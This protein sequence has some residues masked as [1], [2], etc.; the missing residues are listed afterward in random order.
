MYLQ[1]Q[2]LSSGG[3]GVSFNSITVDTE[4]GTYQVPQL[5]TFGAATPPLYPIVSIGSGDIYGTNIGYTLESTSKDF[6]INTLS[7]GHIDTGS[8]AMSSTSIA[9][10]T[11]SQ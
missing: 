4:N 2:D 8:I 5:P 7:L 3:A 10:T 6:S 1:V 11:D 9:G